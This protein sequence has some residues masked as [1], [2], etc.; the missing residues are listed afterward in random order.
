[1][2]ITDRRK[3]ILDVLSAEGEIN[4]TVLS[5]RLGV[6]G[7]T[8]RTDIRALEREGA[9]V[10]FHGGIRL[11]RKTLSYSG[12]NYMVRAVTHVELKNQIGKAAAD[13]VTDGSTIFMDASSTTFHMIPFLQSRK[14]V[15]V[16]T[17]GIHTAMEL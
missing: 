8:L 11:P 16:V 1:M 4:T 13:L 12:E 3:Q 14:N 17:N 6:T 15:T 9:I 7:A 2:G 5:E 10:R